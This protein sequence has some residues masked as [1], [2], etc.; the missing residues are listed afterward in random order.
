MKAALDTVARMVDVRR[1]TVPDAK[2]FVV[3]GDMLELGEDTAYK[4]SAI[5]RYAADSG[6]T[7]VLAIGAEAEHVVSGAVAGGADALRLTDKSE[8]L[9]QLSGLR[10]GD[11]VLVKASRGVGLETVAADL[12]GAPC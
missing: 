4:H 8:A 7:L 5:G 9:R 11:V 6:A 1:T 10:P 3:L 12:L 2:L